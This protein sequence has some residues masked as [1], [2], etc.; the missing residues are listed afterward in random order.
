MGQVEFE[1]RKRD[2]A[3]DQQ[4]RYEQADASCVAGAQQRSQAQRPS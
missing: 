2:D 4:E 3:G 1:Q